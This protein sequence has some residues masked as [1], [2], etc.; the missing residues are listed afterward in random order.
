M[1]EEELER[2]MFRRSLVKSNIEALKD[3]ARNTANTLDALSERIAGLE[4]AY[5]FINTELMNHYHEGVLPKVEV[6]KIFD[7]RDNEKVM[8]KINIDNSGTSIYKILHNLDLALYANSNET[9]DKMGFLF[10][11]QELASEYLKSH[12]DISSAINNMSDYLDEVLPRFIHSPRVEKQLERQ[13]NG[14]AQF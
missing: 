5:E 1:T 11:C 9:I 3:R 4:N 14:R 13:I 2:L 8:L 10:R 7:E 12:H 6:I